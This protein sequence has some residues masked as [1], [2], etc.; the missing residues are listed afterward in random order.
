MSKKKKDVARSIKTRAEP[1]KFLCTMD[2]YETLCCSGYTRLSQ[3]PEIQAAVGKIADLI[4]SMTIHL[5]SNTDKGDV[6]IRNELSKKVDITPNKWMTRKTFISA[7]VRNLLLEGD[8]N[9]VVY[10]E[11][12]N[13]LLMN[14]I[15]LRMGAVSYLE[16][17]YGYL[18]GYEGKYLNPDN[19]LHFVINPDPDYPWKGTGYKTTLKDVAHN[20]KQAAATEKGFMESK[21]KPSIIVK[22]DGLTEEFA[23]KE[24]RGKLL[25]QYIETSEAGEPWM[26]PADQF[27]VQEV[28]PLSLQDIA[29]SDS[30]NVN[31]KTIAAIIGVP[32]FVVGAGKFDKDEWNNFVKTRIGTIC[33]AIEQELTRKLLLSPEWYFRF[34]V[35]SLYAY[36]IR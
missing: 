36:D 5:M 7:V 8:G 29:L 33:N 24:G 15:P 6:R 14:M 19:L 17:G 11:T 2:A 12:Q 18:I 35:R 27:E 30:V 9:A 20:L 34:N 26:I 16:D 22:V 21:W 25:K 10:P 28:R 31:K 23:S 13:G 32:A 4:S 3:N 1:E